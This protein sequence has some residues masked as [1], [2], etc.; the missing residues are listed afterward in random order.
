M[1]GAARGSFAA[2]LLAFAALQASAQ[3]AARPPEFEAASIKPFEPY[4]LP[5]RPGVT[6]TGGGP[7]RM[8]NPGL[9]QCRGTSL[10]G[11]VAQ[12]Y[13]VENFRVFGLDWL[14]SAKFEIEARI[15]HGAT[16]EEVDRMLQKLLAER[17]HLA[18]HRESREMQQYALVVDRNGPKLKEFKG[19]AAP[20]RAPGADPASPPSDAERRQLLQEMTA[21]YDKGAPPAG[22]LRTG[23]GPD[24]QARLEAFGFTMSGLAGL[25]SFQLR[26]TVVDRTDLK[27]EY[28][29]RL[30][31]VPGEGM[32]RQ[33][34]TVSRDGGPPVPVESTA[35]GPS[36]FSALESQLGLKLEPRKVP[37]ETIV[38]DACDR[39]P[40]AN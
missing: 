38:V 22:F 20:V 21:A 32:Q 26:Q 34:M 9:L 31:Y 10:L 7:C 2:G 16:R 14:D 1:A 28:E 29:I 36:I 5:D 33:T 27:G 30:S 18:V 3:E 12:A 19:P 17:F 4:R 35:V 13:G 25:L 40:T 11:L 37:V 39:T 23:N 15:P 6:V 24:G 8:P